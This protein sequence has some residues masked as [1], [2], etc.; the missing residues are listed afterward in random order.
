[1][2][3]ILQQADNK[4][5]SLQH[6]EN[7]LDFLQGIRHSRK[8]PVFRQFDAILTTFTHKINVIFWKALLLFRWGIFK[9][10]QFQFFMYVI[11]CILLIAI[12][13]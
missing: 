4:M 6:A 7:K 11:V 9:C 10:H 12:N 5:T 3:T 8:T 1:M 2:V 13:E